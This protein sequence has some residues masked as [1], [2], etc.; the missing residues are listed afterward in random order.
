MSIFRDVEGQLCFSLNLAAVKDL[1]K[2]D[3]GSSSSLF[4][5]PNLSLCHDSLKPQVSPLPWTTTLKEAYRAYPYKQVAGQSPNIFF[6]PE[7]NDFHMASSEMGLLRDQ[8]T[9]TQRLIFSWTHFSHTRGK[10]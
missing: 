1:P 8:Q 4:T 9:P 3:Q 5:N 6:S 2:P 10:P 7:P